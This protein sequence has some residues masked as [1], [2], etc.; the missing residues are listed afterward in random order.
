MSCSKLLNNWMFETYFACDGACRH[1]RPLGPYPSQPRETLET[2][3]KRTSSIHHAMFVKREPTCSRVFDVERNSE[4]RL[5]VCGRWA[6]TRSQKRVTC[7]DL[8]AP[9]GEEPPRIVVWEANE[10]DDLEVQR[11][12]CIDVMSYDGCNRAVAVLE[13][14]TEGP[15]MRRTEIVILNVH[16]NIASSPAF[17]LKKY[18]DDQ[19][20]PTTTFDTALVWDIDQLHKEPVIIPKENTV[21]DDARLTHFLTCRTHLITFIGDCIVPLATRIWARPLASVLAGTTNISASATVNYMFFK[22]ITMLQSSTFDP[23][24]I[25]VPSWTGSTRILYS[26]DEPPYGRLAAA[27]VAYNEETQTTSIIRAPN[28]GAESG[29]QE[30]FR[31]HGTELQSF[32]TEPYKG[33]ILYSHNLPEDGSE[34]TKRMQLCLIGFA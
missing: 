23:F 8:D 18:T 25:I 10:E 33:R 19:K 22:E 24:L 1:P 21:I 5:P 12:Y 6:F 9:D 29:V 15:P 13:L 3:V 4:T 2:I 11:L 28:L 30:H 34:R 32:E 16:F 7:M 14:N 20:R 17:I 26:L 27:E 31:W